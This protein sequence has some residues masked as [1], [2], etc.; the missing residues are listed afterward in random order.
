MKSIQVTVYQAFDGSRFDTEDACREYEAEA[1]P[2]RFVGLTIEQV[3]DALERRDSELADAF[4][5]AGQRIAQL[6][7]EAGEF[8]RASPKRQDDGGAPEPLTTMGPVTFA[9]GA[10]SIPIV[11]TIAE[12]TG[13]R[14]DETEPE[15][16]E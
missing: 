8:R 2:R 10:T 12:F 1:W 14:P 9:N 4:E 15:A 16:A 6:R 13:Q 7:R 5:R 3:N 11:E